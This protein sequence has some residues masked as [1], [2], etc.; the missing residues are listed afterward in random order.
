MN[1]FE[2]LAEWISKN[3]PKA[4]KIVEVGV[5]RTSRTIEKLNELLPET[6]F[7]ATD[8]RK[9]SVPNE[10]NFKLDDITEPEMSIYDNTDL[11]YS[12]R[13]PP[14]LYNSIFELAEKINADAL[15]KP[16]SSEESPLK[17][18]LINYSGVFFYLLKTSGKS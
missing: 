4:E 2:L 7:V 3:Y 9:V 5:G 1:E 16:I 15:V 12:L 10:I 13:S 8:N 6:Y 14:E 18:N 11:V 17:G